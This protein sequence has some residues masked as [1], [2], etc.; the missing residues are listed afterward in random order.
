MREPICLRPA[1]SEL[2]WSSASAR[3]R[4]RRS[5]KSTTPVMTSRPPALAGSR[6][7]VDVD[8]VIHRALEKR[9]EDR[10]SN[11][12]AMREALETALSRSGTSIVAQATQHAK[13]QH[14][15][16]RRRSRLVCRKQFS[17]RLN[18]G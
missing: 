13:G 15:Q 6:T 11:A 4:A 14:D 10:Y 2:K 18:G 17:L 16:A 8:V 5:W 9:P 1:P 3:F 7:I 12:R